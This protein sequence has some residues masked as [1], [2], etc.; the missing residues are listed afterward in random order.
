MSLEQAVTDNTVAIRDL[1]AAL[2]KSSGVAAA[3]LL[4]NS[5]ST[6]VVEKAVVVPSA[7]ASDV[8]TIDITYEQLS[9]EFLALI[10]KL[11][12]AAAA[13]AAV[14]TPLGLENLKD[15]SS[16]VELFPAIWEKIQKAAA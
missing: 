4:G 16:K 11:G 7:A 8:S 3:P 14:L 15:N 5:S 2:S 1:I 13:K 6:A 10:R 9:K 12:S